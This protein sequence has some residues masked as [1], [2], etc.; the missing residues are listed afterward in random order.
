[1]VPQT[2]RFRKNRHGQPARPATKLARGYEAG[3]SASPCIVRSR[4]T[5]KPVA[6]TRESRPD[7]WAQWLTSTANGIILV[8]G[9]KVPLGRINAGGTVTVHAAAETLAIELPDGDT[10]VVRRTNENAVR[11]IKGQRP[12]STERSIS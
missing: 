1:M 8:A 6:A 3:P 5:P 4:A 12:R 7:L 9:Q 10:K 11:S 2:R